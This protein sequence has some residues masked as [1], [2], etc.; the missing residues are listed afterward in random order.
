MDNLVTVKLNNPDEVEIKEGVI[1]RFRKNFL[2]KEL[3][4]T[5]NKGNITGSDKLLFKGYFVSRADL[6]QMLSDIS[7]DIILPDKTSFTELLAK[8]SAD[9]AVKKSNENGIGIGINFGYGHSKQINDAKGTLIPISNE[10]Q[11]V[12]DAR[13]IAEKGKPSK[14]VSC[15]TTANLHPTDPPITP[16]NGGTPYPDPRGI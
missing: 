3:S 6:I 10:L 4:S 9:P 5:K 1:N 15:Y 7:E 12:F 14:T 13:G 16:P 2:N 8:V 11:L